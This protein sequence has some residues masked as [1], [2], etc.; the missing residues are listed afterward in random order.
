MFSHMKILASNFYI[1][2]FMRMSMGRCQE[3]GKG[4]MREVGKEVLRE[5]SGEG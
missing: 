4:P 2:I 3:T 5:R 1:C